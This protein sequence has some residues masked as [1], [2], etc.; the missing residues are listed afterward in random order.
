MPQ[1]EW[2]LEDYVELPLL[3]SSSFTERAV[4]HTFARRPGLRVRRTQDTAVWVQR[5]RAAGVGLVDA[6]AF[7]GPKAVAQLGLEVVSVE[8]SQ[9]VFVTPGLTH[10]RTCVSTLPHRNYLGSICH[11]SGRC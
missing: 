6:A 4:R 9:V 11:S 1:P 10:R 7:V 2:E 3:G 8:G 5:M